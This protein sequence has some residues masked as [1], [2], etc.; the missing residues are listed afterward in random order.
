MN[1]KIPSPAT[2]WN[3]SSNQ[4]HNSQL[5]CNIKFPIINLKIPNP[6]SHRLKHLFQPQHCWSLREKTSLHSFYKPDNILYS[7]QRL[8][9]SVP[10]LF[11]S[12][13]VSSFTLLFATIRAFID[14]DFSKKWSTLIWFIK[15]SRRFV[16]QY[17]F[18]FVHHH[19]FQIIIFFPTAFC[20]SP[21]NGCFCR[22][23]TEIFISNSIH[24]SF[25]ENT[26]L[27]RLRISQQ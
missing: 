19:F 9:W 23:P 27:S 18:A 17:L 5:I 21:S 15:I 12:S 6:A 7:V 2:G 10:L 3:I 8:Y 26:Q 25:P 1:L 4:F 13:R 20:R 22:F 14:E 11:H 16:H 24:L